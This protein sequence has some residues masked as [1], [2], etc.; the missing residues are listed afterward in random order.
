[1]ILLIFVTIYIYQ[2]F[3]TKALEKGLSKIKWGLWGS[4]IYLGLGLGLQLFVGVLI[5]AGVLSL[6]IENMGISIVLSLVTYAIGALAAYLLY[7]KL[8]RMEGEEVKIDEF[9]KNNN[10]ENH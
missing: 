1:M 5:G 9:G 6:D 3:S 2:K 8:S 7:Q 4:G 10:L